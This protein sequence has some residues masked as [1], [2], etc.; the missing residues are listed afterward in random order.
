M[1]PNNNIYKLI[2]GLK[3]T[4]SAQLDAKVNNAI[5]DAL[6]QRK[7]I[8]SACPEHSR[9]A[10][11]NIG[12]IIMRSPITKLAAAAVII[13]AVLAGIYVITGKAPAVTCCA[14]A[15]IADKVEQIKTCAYRL[16]VRQTGGPLGQTGQQVEGKV[17]ISSDYGYR[18]ETS[19][20]G[21]PM[22]QMY[23]NPGEKAMIIV[24]PAQKKY[25]RMVLTD[26]TLAKT[27]KQMQDPRDI[28]TQFMS[29]QPGQYKELGKDTINGVEVKGIEVNNPPA[30]QGIYSDFTG[31]MWVDVATEYPVRM[32]IEGE[33]K[34]GGQNINMIIVMDGF[35]WG[36]ELSPDLF[37]PDIPA[38]FTTMGEMKLPTQNETGAIEGFKLFAE[39]MDG[40]Y[41]SQMNAIA[42]VI[43][44]QEGLTKTSNATPGVEPNDQVQQERMN[45]VMKLQGPFIFYQKL[46]Q[47]GNE[48]AYYGDKVTS[49]F[50]D[51]VLM[52]WKGSDKQYRVIFGNL[53]VK[54]V[55]ADELA[56]L[57]AMPLN[58]QPKAINPKPADGTMCKIGDLELSWMPGMYAAT[59]KVYMGTASDGLTL[60]A[61]AASDSNMIVQ[62]LKR[63]TTYYWRVD[64]IDANGKVTTGDV[65]S[66]N[67][68]KLVGWW[69]FDEST[70]TIASDS[71]G[72]GNNGTL[73][74]NPVWRPTG[75][76]LGGAI[77]LSGKGDYVEIN[78]ESAFDINGQITISAWVNIT[79][80]PQEWTGIVTKG[81]SAWRLSTSF[82]QNVFHFGVSSSAY[83]NGQATVDSGQWHNVVGVYDGQKM[84]IY[85]DGKIDFSRPWTRPIGTNDFPVCIGENIELKGRCF[86][87]L[88]DDVRIYNYALSQ[89]EIIELFNSAH[90]VT[91]E[92]KSMPAGMEFNAPTDIQQWDRK[93]FTGGQMDQWHITKSGQVEAHVQMI[94]INT[95]A[96]TC[97]MTVTLPYSDASIIS[98]KLGDS[99]LSFNKAKAVRE[100]N[101]TVPVE[102]MG[103]IDAGQ[104]EIDIV[105]TMPLD[106][107][108][109]APYGYRAELAGLIP[110][111]M[112]KL[113]VVL[114][115]GCGYVFSKDPSRSEYL[116]FYQDPFGETIQEPKSY[117]GSCGI[118]IKPVNQQ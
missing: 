109:K 113:T 11:P 85:V 38:D 99:P 73:K 55:S 77:E 26:E 7:R 43:E 17:Y 4:P 106:K 92:A 2:E 111:S 29:G 110:V 27:K 40:K 59:N 49:E 71:S 105:W 51:A 114:D 53:T 41:P 16:H 79:D 116:A 118:P 46:R 101:V 9:R 75:G 89:D 35:E 74:G 20:N 23:M 76:V 44:A 54:T 12:R 91:V 10:Q 3:T 50:G 112:Y 25:M 83:L 45:K 21:I 117:F 68:G 65:W 33:M 28:I 100:Y 103:K 14:W 58:R 94:I 22:Q 98:A 61:D 104:R 96:D 86:H 8:E 95:P 42:A 13:I 72:N 107:L 97:V 80:V 60:L 82:A 78:N 108:E 37:K 69:K 5:D 64:E 39:I 66:F 87:G 32:E 62:E 34:I 52:R 1:K 24:M 6:A 93:G 19:L 81:D 84:S 90:Y 57:E 18:M 102:K 30:V 36:V 70:G 15:Q 47:E 115:K 88:I 63:D 67:T 48:P 31:R 56:V